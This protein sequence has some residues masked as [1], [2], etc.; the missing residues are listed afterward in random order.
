MKRIIL[1]TITILLTAA[2]FSGCADVEGEKSSV[3]PPTISEQITENSSNVSISNGETDETSSDISSVSTTC[4]VYKQKVKTFTEEQLLSFFSVTPERTFYEET[5]T[6][7]YSSDKENGNVS[8]TN[9]IFYTETG[10]LCDIAYGEAYGGETQSDEEDL[11]FL[12]RDEVLKIANDSLQSMGLDCYDWEANIIYSIKAETLDAFKEKTYKSAMDNPYSLD[13]QELQKEIDTAQRLYKLP[14]KD[15]YYMEFRPEFDGI[16]IYSGGM[17]AYGSNDKI[18]LPSS[19]KIYISKDGIEYFFVS[20]IPETETYEEVN[21]IEFNTAKGWID[22]KYSEIIFDGEVKVNNIELVYI[23]IPLN[24]LE[25]INKNFETRPFYAFYCTI[26]ESY[27]GEIISNDIITYFDAVT[28]DE[29]ATER[30]GY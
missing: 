30:V 26:N 28:G 21:I 19:C 3:I 24:D 25:N 6:V 4:K 9:L 18:V 1:N 29:F 11:D 20:N 12:S 14:S 23:P 22:K 15:L 5:D 10:L 16:P 8:Q 17:L 7:I 13:E 27:D 2:L